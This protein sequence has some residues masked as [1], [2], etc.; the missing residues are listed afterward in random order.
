MSEQTAGPGSQA[1]AMGLL[2]MWLVTPASPRSDIR[3]SESCVHIR[4]CAHTHFFFYPRR[5]KKDRFVF[6][7]KLLLK[8]VVSP[9]ACPT[10]FA[11]DVAPLPPLQ[12]ASSGKQGPT[13]QRTSNAP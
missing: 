1:S 6:F 8:L 9:K 2:R 3:C 12:R 5:K 11:P 13:R 4:T 7:L 10:V